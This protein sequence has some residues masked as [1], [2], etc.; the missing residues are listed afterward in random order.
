MFLCYTTNRLTSFIIIYK[1][2][3]KLI[4]YL[5]VRLK[6]LQMKWV[7]DKAPHS[8][9]IL[10]WKTGRENLNV[11]YKINFWKQNL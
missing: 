8:S 6:S 7:F 9:L 4:F 1:Y 2:Q 10:Y 3:E 11:K 5:F